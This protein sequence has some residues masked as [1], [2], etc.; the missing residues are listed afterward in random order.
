MSHKLLCKLYESS[1]LNKSCIHGSLL[2]RSM[3][4]VHPCQTTQPP[5]S[6]LRNPN[7]QTIL[8]ETSHNWNDTQPTKTIYLSLKI[9]S[10][11]MRLIFIHAEGSSPAEGPVAFLLFHGLPPRK[12]KSQPNKACNINMTFISFRDLPNSKEVKC[13]QN[14]PPSARAA[15]PATAMPTIP[16][17]SSR[18]DTKASSS[19][20]ERKLRGKEAKENHTC[21]CLAVSRFNLEKGSDVF[22]GCGIFLQ[23]RVAQIRR[24]KSKNISTYF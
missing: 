14:W 4:L 10:T 21:L 11:R 22:Q 1:L 8:L 3:S 20:A 6:K 2:Q 7:S 23:T 17:F 24:D 9:F 18:L 15:P 12:G 16:S 5:N 19:F 13:Q